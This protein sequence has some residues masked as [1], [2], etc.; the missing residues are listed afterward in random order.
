MHTWKPDTY[1]KA[2]IPIVAIFSSSL[3]NVALLAVLRFKN[4]TDQA[5]GPE[6]AQNLL[7]LFGIISI[8]IPAL[9]MLTQHN[10]KRLLAYSSIEQSGI[11]VLGF[12]F[13][14]LATFG[15]ILHMIFH[16]LAKA[17]LF[18]LS[19]NIFLQYSSTKIANVKNMLRFLPATSI[20][21]FIA[22]L[23]V[24][25]IPPSGLFLTE[26]YIFSTGITSHLA[27]SIVAI[28]SIAIVFIGFL[29]VTSALIFERDEEYVNHTSHMENKWL[30]VPSVIILVV[31]VI[32]S[33]FLP[34]T[35][36]S[37]IESASTLYQ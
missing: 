25:G 7:I 8:V 5:V 16:S 35:L 26:F 19:G 1:A 20:L 31:F 36:R 17:A 27:I 21:F 23:A 24:A 6:F 14:G 28:V 2:P 18:L 12:A 32:L 3:L 33:L 4:I 37:L 11:I 10:Y 15:A 34:S 30:L 22:V 9:I 13:G 29:K